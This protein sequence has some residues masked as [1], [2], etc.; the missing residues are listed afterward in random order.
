MPVF[1]DKTIRRILI[2][3]GGALGDFILTLPAI[4]ALRRRWP[5]AYI[6]L[7]GYEKNAGLA[8][9]AGLVNRIQSLDSAR[10][11]LFFQKE[12]RL[13][14]DEIEYIRSFDLMVT[15]LHDP[16]G[17]FIGHLDEAGAKNIIAASPLVGKC[18]AA[19]HFREAIENIGGKNKF[20]R[21]LAAGT[22]AHFIKCAHGIVPQKEEFQLKWPQGLKEKARLRLVEYLGGKR[23]I[24]IHPGSGSFA[25]NWPAAKF[26]ALAEKIRAETDCRPLVIGGE[27]DQKEIAVLRQLL[28]GYCIRDN[29]PLEDVASLL[30][31]ADG[32][33]G[34][35]S[36]VTH[37]AAV[38]GIPVVAVFGPTDPAV[39]APRGK[40]VSVVKSRLRSAES[41]A[42][43]GVDEV[44]QAMIKVLVDNS[45]NACGIA[46]GGVR[47]CGG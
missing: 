6:E 13:P 21:K 44:F 37:L 32:Y 7:A 31:V 12:T 18:H 16:D 34:N 10:M 24:I 43:I 39:W 25:K 4:A 1:A 38:L 30:S 33:V 14:P 11:A 47:W 29:L 41:L 42:G 17:V 9:T 28:H 8:L 45:H 27:A 2:F 23:A 46:G 3:R 36:G 22:W 20:A 15:F 19:D 35:D 40:N 5:G 26:A